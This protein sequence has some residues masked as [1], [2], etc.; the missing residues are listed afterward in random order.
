M[1]GAPFP[2]GVNCFSADV[3]PALRRCR[4]IRLRYTAGQIPDTHSIR[5]SVQWLCLRRG[6]PD[7]SVFRRERCAFARHP[8][9]RH[10]EWETASLSD[11]VLIPFEFSP[12]SVNLRLIFQEKCNIVKPEIQAKKRDASDFSEI[13]GS[14]TDA[15]K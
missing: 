10:R 5:A 11:V 14:A 4:R 13:L 3:R 7:I 2:I 9:R 8:M 6:R 12:L 15:P 1:H